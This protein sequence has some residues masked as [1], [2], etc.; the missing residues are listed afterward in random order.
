MRTAG[1]AASIG[2]RWLFAGGGWGVEYLTINQPLWTGPA[3]TQVSG[4]RIKPSEKDALIAKARQPGAG[5]LTLFLFA[6][7]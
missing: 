3:A 6:A 4:G 2:Q 5:I 7:I 1:I